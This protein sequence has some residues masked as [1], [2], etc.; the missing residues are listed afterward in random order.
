MI[1]RK[2][3]GYRSPDR[4]GSGVGAADRVADPAI[5]YAGNPAEGQ[6]YAGVARQ[7]APHRR[8]DL[9]WFGARRP[10]RSRSAGAVAVSPQTPRITWRKRWCV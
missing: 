6:A 9:A 8:G 10:D 3:R 5:G 1:M 2:T 7:E 4:G